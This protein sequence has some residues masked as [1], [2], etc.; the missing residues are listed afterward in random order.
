[1]TVETTPYVMPEADALRLTNRITLIAG[2]I[3][4]G[5]EKLQGLVAEAKNGNAHIVLGY[6]SWTAYLAATLGKEPMRLGREERQQLVGYLAGEGMSTRAIAP[7]VGAHHDTVAT[8][9]KAA[10][11]VGNPTPVAHATPV[12]APSDADLIAGSDWTPETPAEAVGAADD[13]VKAEPRDGSSALLAPRPEVTGLDGKT[14]TRPEATKP[15]RKP[16]T[17]SARDA[18]WELRKA[19]ERLTRLAEDDRFTPN[20]EQVATLLRSHLSNAIEVC[21]DLLDRFPEDSEEN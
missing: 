16:I 18:G 2:T 15:R 5:M 13:A 20:E 8:D 19:V 7:I 1:M 11:P 21:Q 6:P 14:Y 3:R 10:R 17:D 12:A 4:E 9:I